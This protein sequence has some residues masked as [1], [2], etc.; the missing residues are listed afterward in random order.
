M[1]VSGSLCQ[2]LCE[3]TCLCLQDGVMVVHGG[4]DGK[5]TFGHTWK[6][7]TADWTWQ[8]MATTGECMSVHDV[9][10]RVIA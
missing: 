4:F 2:C 5:H 9:A 7:S 1:L 3:D 8:Q 10:C 6:L